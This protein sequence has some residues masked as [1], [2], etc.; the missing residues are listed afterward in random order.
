MKPACV[1]LIQEM[2]KQKYISVHKH[3]EY[4]LYI[5]NYTKQASA[6]HIWNEATELCRG[7]ILGKDMNIVARPFAKFYNYEELVEQHIQ[8]PDLPFE[9]YEKLD[10]SLGIMYF[11]N[12]KPYIATRGS[13]DSDQAIHAN[14]LLYDKY[15]DQVHL[16]DQTK[17]YLF[18]IIY[19]DP[20]VRSNLIVDYGDTDDIFLLA[21]IDTDTGIED[22]I[23]QYKHIFKTAQRYDSVKD[24][25]QFRNEQNGKN[26]EGFVI[27]FA[28]GFRMKLKF[29]EY[30]KAHYVKSHL[31][32]KDILN[33]IMSNKVF[34]LRKKVHD[35]D[36][37][38]C[39]IYFDDVANEI[40]MKYN[41]I[42]QLCHKDLDANTFADRKTAAQYF[43]KCKYPA[44]LFKMFDQRSFEDI[45]WKIVEKECC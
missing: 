17:T 8:I 4:E 45:V 42:V 2:I 43:L 29:E 40:I 11:V 23:E 44:V 10:G 39:L 3:P 25:L 12:S 13:F 16:L 5:Y 26:R 33:A 24:Y 31:S 35:L 27:K 37:E 15:I 20:K 6:E 9:V 28:N 36:S 18:E 14:K 19:N 22:D 21:V 30:F 1:Q 7:L 38:E 41:D 34:E 32:R